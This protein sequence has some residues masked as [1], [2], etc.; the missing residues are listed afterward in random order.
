MIPATVFG[1]VIFN[2]PSFLKSTTMLAQ[3]IT[4]GLDWPKNVT[5]NDKNWQ[6]PVLTKRS[7]GAGSDTTV[8]NYIKK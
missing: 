6:F 7:R 4:I 3:H 1:Y 8:L 5:K 2:T